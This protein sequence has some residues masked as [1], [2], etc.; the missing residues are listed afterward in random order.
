MSYETTESIN[1]FSE[2]DQ[3]LMAQNV[4]DWLIDFFKWE[5]YTEEDL[6]EM[7]C[8]E[9]WRQASWGLGFGNQYYPYNG[10]LIKYIRERFTPE[11]SLMTKMLVGGKGDANS[12]PIANTIRHAFPNSNKVS[13]EVESSRIHIEDLETFNVVE[14]P[15]EDSP[16]DFFVGAFDAGHLPMYEHKE[17][18]E[19]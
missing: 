13:I 3:K 1:A 4:I 10:N 14:I 12:C 16:V 8:I 6:M 18:W 5:T 19:G 9:D 2:D 15:C 7:C 11:V 17:E